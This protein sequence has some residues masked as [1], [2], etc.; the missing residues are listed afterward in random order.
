[1]AQQQPPA[2]DRNDTPPTG[3][4]WQAVGYLVA[5]VVVYGLAGWG[6]DRWLGTNWIVAIGIL[7]GAA[8]G[9]YMTWLRF[10]GRAGT[11]NNVDE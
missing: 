11:N 1:M 4:P 10:G 5:G 2:S 8:L 6:L 3:D 7:F 9:V